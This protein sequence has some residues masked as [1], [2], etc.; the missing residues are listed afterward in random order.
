LTEGDNSCFWGGKSV[1]ADPEILKKYSKGK[2]FVRIAPQW[3]NEAKYNTGVF[4]VF[5]K[6][7]LE[8]T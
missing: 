8:I 7:Q 4:S 1:H 6:K 5:S 2:Y 3:V